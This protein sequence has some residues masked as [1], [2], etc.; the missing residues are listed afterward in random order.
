MATSPIITRSGHTFIR[1]FW[2]ERLLALSVIAL[3]AQLRWPMLSAWYLRPRPGKNVVVELPGQLPTESIHH[4]WLYL[5]EEYHRSK[6][7]PLGVYLHGSGQRGND[8]DLVNRLGLSRQITLGK[9]YSFLVLSTMPRR[10]GMGTCGCRGN[11]GSGG[12]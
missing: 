12:K 11:Y 8:P 2:L 9:N 4:Y 6:N 7:W 5:P 1:R 10:T 3:V